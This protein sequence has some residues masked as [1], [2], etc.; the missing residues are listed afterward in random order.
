[1]E[2]F[3]N[4]GS[5]VGRSEPG[6]MTHLDGSPYR[7]EAR[8]LIRCPYRL[9]HGIVNAPYEKNYLI[10]VYCPG[11]SRHLYLYT[12]DDFKVL[13]E[14][15][16]FARIPQGENHVQTGVAESHGEEVVDC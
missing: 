12:E 3:Q 5:W 14:D 1:V 16:P 8:M 13:A 7:Y 15:E 10:S 9:C 6:S 2:E 4:P 11:C